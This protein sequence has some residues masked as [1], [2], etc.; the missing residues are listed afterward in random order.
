LPTQ[1]PSGS[2]R[3][4]E[5]F[6]VE[7]QNETGAWVGNFMGGAT[8][9]TKVFEHLDGR[10]V[11]V[12]A[13][14]QGYVVNSDS[15]EVSTFGGALTGIAYRGVDRFVFSTFTELEAY[16]TTGLRWRTRRLSWDGFRSFRAEGGILQGEAWTPIGEKWTEFSVDLSTGEATGGA[17][18]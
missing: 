5:G 3:Y 16:G 1:F 11:I 6:V 2:G 10:S 17:Y 7:F 13:G 12:I 4:R 15:Q 9:F 18:P 8:G 14:G